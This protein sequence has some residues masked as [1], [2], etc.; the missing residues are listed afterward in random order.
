MI[1]NY[2]E[3][4]ANERTFLAWVRTAIAIVGFGLA[5][6]RLGSQT[7]SLWTEVLMMTSGAL[8]VLLAWLRMRHIRTRIDDSQK[9]DDESTPNDTLL[10]FLVAA[11]VALLAAFGAH[12]G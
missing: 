12:V 4:A 11:L 6:A 5:T 10:L 8:V 1:E 7:P 2:S 3:H 9:F